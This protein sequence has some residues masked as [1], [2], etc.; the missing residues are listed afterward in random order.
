MSIHTRQNRKYCSN[1][2]CAERYFV[3]INLPRRNMAIRLRKKIKEGNKITPNGKLMKDVS[4]S[5]NELSSSEPML[6]ITTSSK[7]VSS[8]Y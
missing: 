2:G 1:K 6:Y 7:V 3:R 8:S 5:F 4:Y